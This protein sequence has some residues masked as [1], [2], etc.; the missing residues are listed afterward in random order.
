MKM[1]IIGDAMS[2]SMPGSAKQF[3]GTVQ[4][5]PIGQMIVYLGILAVLPIIGYLIA[6]LAIGF[7]GWG[8]TYG[9]ISAIG[10]V[11]G[12]VIAGFILAAISNGV[13]GRQVSNEEAVTVIGYASTPIFLVGFLAGLMSMSWQLMGIAG[14]LGLLALIYVV[15]LL[16]LAGGARYGPDKA[17]VFAIVAVAVLFIVYLVM[18]AIATSIAMSVGGMGMYGGV[19]YYGTPAASGCITY[20]GT[21]VCY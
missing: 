5:K 11:I 7:V 18:G 2:A 9:I 12:I 19:G 4:P 15:Y 1:N 3:L 13:V 21:T 16:Y 8:L 14:L 17:I 20:Q 10:T 6:G